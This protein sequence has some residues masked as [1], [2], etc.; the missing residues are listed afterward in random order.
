MTQS[1]YLMQPRRQNIAMKIALPIIAFLI[2]MI[3]AVFT[4][5]TVW[6]SLAVSISIYFFCEFL[7]NLGKKIVVMDL[8]II[9]AVFTCLI[10]PVVFYH[11]YT[12]ENLLARIWV[13]YMPIPSDEYFSFVLPAIL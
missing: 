12:Q 5:L 7:E 10:M 9:M 3:C 4:T 11:D 2:F 1:G 6:E 8:A 13:K